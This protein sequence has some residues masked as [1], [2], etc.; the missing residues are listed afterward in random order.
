MLLHK[1]ARC[2]YEDFD[3]SEPY[4]I[5]QVGL[6]VIDVASILGTVD[7]CGELDRKFRY[8]KRGDLAE[9]LRRLNVQNAT[10]P[11]EFLPPISVYRFQGS[12]YVVD[13]H[14]RVAA[15]L[16]N[17]MDYIDADIK[18][19]VHQKDEGARTGLFARRRIESEA[20]LKQIR[21]KRNE[22]YAFLLEEIEAYPG[23]ETLQEKAS[24]WANERFYP[25]CRAIERSGLSSRYP[26]LYSGDIYA[27][28]L[29]FY[30][31]FMGDIPEGMSSETLISGYLFAHRLRQRRIYRIPFFGL[32]FRAL[33]RIF[34]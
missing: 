22:N 7:K 11:F 5:V 15:A 32:V 17:K 8:I 10:N 14:R 18:E 4:S 6:R 3:S 12:Y 16:Q 20:G 29:S 9:Y 27:L 24:K 34:S 33:R 26:D 13:G 19:F 31:D 21:L 25:F 30:R 23:G 28:V 2:F 1:P